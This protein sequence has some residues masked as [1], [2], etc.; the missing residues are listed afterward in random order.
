MKKR[1]LSFLLG[2]SLA[3]SAFAGE[4]RENL[5]GGDGRP[6]AGPELFVQLGHAG[7]MSAAVFSPDGRLI[8]TAGLDH[9]V[10][11][12]DRATGRELRRLRDSE[13]GVNALAF[14]PDGRLILTGGGN[15]DGEQRLWTG[16]GSH[17]SG[18]LGGDRPLRP[19]DHLARL[20]D[21]RTG[22]EV[23]QLLGHRTM[24]TAVAFSPDGARVLTGSADGAVRLWTAATGET[25]RKLDRAHRSAVRAISFSPDGAVFLTAGEDG[26]LRLWSAAEQ[27]E[28]RQWTGSSALHSAGFSADGRLVLTLAGGGPPLPGQA[29]P[30]QRACAWSAATGEQV[31]CLAWAVLSP[32]GLS[33]LFLEPVSPFD[34]VMG[35]GEDRARLLDLA[36]GAERRLHLGGLRGSAFLA[37]SPDG[38]QLL[39]RHHSEGARLL[40]LAGDGR[41]VALE[42]L[43]ISAWSVAVSPGGSRIAVGG[44]DGSIH[45]WQTATGTQEA[46][47]LRRVE[48]GRPGAIGVTA[49]AFPEDDRHLLAL[50][51]DIA[52][53]WDLESGAEV[54]TSDPGPFAQSHLAADRRTLLQGSHG[55][56]ALALRDGVSGAVR[57]RA[58]PLQ[59]HVLALSRQARLVVAQD[60]QGVVGKELVRRRDLWRFPLEAL[61]AAF[62]PDEQTVAVAAFEGDV[63]LLDAATGKARW[64]ARLEPPVAALAFSADGRRLAAANDGGLAVLWDTASGKRLLALA[65]HQA[66]ITGLAFSPDG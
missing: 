59:E 2:L 6:A 47:V 25:V 36:T 4:A 1:Q 26:T 42:R 40:E 15:W 9:F 49:L 34:Q 30:E 44:G 17:Q 11:L 58:E 39:L 54:R 46:R 23:R 37:F 13:L 8:A 62:S 19:T 61:F 31:R 16:A 55:E 10:R 50:G 32:D 60:E 35:R 48:E 18:V 12:W 65:G 52:R 27:R 56:P 41:P 28:V 3:A 29:T 14:S 45:L 5:P 22:R 33:A 38:R 43:A 24:V 20:W 63:A 64:R 53:L 21:A 57:G 51:Q 66:G 7:D